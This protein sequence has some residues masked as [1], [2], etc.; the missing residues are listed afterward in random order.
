M[1][2]PLLAVLLA[3][4]LA[5]CGEDI[6]AEPGPEPAPEEQAPAKI[7]HTVQADGSVITVVDATDALVWVGLDLD[8]RERVDPALASAWDLS[9]QRFHVRSRGGVNGT[10]GVQVAVLPD[11][12]D[13]VSTAPS[14]GYR[15]DAPDGEDTNTE[16]D[17]AFE[18]EGGWYSY[19]VSSHTLTPR[20]RT[21]VV[22]SD[23][24]QFFKLQILG[25]YDSAG[26]P[27][28]LSFR[29]KQVAAPLNPLIP[30]GVN[31]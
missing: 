26:T 10:G 25:Y 7:R 30:D 28:M 14:S 17:T 4:C 1:S 22:R 6:H 29:W 20:A 27:A 15:E 21:Y 19:D 11:A 23:A 16:S 31:P 9:F 18:A 3:S 24:G 12:F 2:R 13:A 8:T 5:A